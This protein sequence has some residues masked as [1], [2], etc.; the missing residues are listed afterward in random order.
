[1]TKEG[2]FGIGL[3]IFLLMLILFIGGN[4]V[5]I[6]DVDRNPLIGTLVAFVLTAI[7][8]AGAILVQPFRTRLEK[9]AKEN[10]F[11][12][13][14]EC[15]VLIYGLHRSGKTSL[16]SHILTN[17]R[18]YQRDSTNNF[19]IFEE[20]LR[21]GLNNPKRYRVT[22]ADY[23]G[24]KPSQISTDYPEK[25]F[26]LKG[27]RKINAIIFVV[28]LFPEIRNENGNAIHDHDLLENFKENALA[29][30]EDRVS[31]NLKY[32]NKYTIEPVFAVSFS[33]RNMIAIK[34]LVNKLDLLRELVA[35]GCLP[36]MS[37]EDINDFV[38]DLYHPAIEC[39]QQACND[40]DFEDFSTHLLSAKTGENVHDMFA[41]VLENYRLKVD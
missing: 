39:I 17:E 5:D 1:M 33:K 13:T 30:I 23:K 9:F 18:P 28:D 14:D 6:S 4:V 25:F 37:S 41:D 3:L 32:I 10:I 8:S 19:D 29:K 26:G 31:E 34:F 2:Y 20:R 38:L 40:N 15:R 12:S 24:Q 16:I 21:I 7:A 22:I 11:V 36:D 27:Q 35:N